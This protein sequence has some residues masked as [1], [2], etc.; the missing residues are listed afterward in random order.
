MS[1]SPRYRVA[2]LTHG[3]ER[4]LSET[5]TSFEAY[6]TPRPLDWIILQDGPGDWTIPRVFEGYAGQAWSGQVGFC[7]ATRRLWHLASRSGEVNYGERGDGFYIPPAPEFIFWLEHDFLFLRPLD[8]EP[9]MEQLLLD[10]RLAQMSLMRQAVSSDEIEAGGVVEA[11][12]G[13]FELVRGGPM[14]EHPFLRHRSYFTTNP[15]LMRTGFMLDRPW[16]DYPQ[17]CEG[18]FGLDLIQHGYDFGVWG[19]GDPWIAHIGERTG[20]GY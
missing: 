19:D 16:P 14:G 20:H 7:E 6:V 13:Q 11:R 4:H 17:E 12:P 10:P 5:L 2:C 3:D 9:L 8:L 15:S 18:R 1:A